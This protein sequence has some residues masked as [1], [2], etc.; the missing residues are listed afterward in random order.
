MAKS[1]LPLIP[2]TVYF[3]MATRG[4]YVNAAPPSYHT[5]PLIES[6]IQLL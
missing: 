4:L 6:S 2:G 1:A 3:G 5:I